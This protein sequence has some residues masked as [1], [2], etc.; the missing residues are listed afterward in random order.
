MKAIAAREAKNRFGTLMDTAQREPVAI[1][2][3]GRPVAVLMSVEEYN[4][5]KFSRLQA[6]IKAGVDQ[7]DGDES[8][9]FG[10]AELGDLFEGIKRQG[11]SR[12]NV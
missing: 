12:R 3:H 5:I 1:E 6:E 7:L 2:K 8:T 9:V 4:T 10:R 11:R